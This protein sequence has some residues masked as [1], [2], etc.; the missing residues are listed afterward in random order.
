MRTAHIQAYVIASVLLLLGTDLPAQPASDV[1]QIGDQFYLRTEQVA[2]TLSPSYWYYRQ[3]MDVDEGVC[4][5]FLQDYEDPMYSVGVYLRHFDSASQPLH[6]SLLAD[7][8]HG[9][10]ASQCATARAGD[11]TWTAWSEGGDYLWARIFDVYGVPY[12]DTF[13][14]SELVGMEYD[15]SVCVRSDG[16]RTAIV[17]AD[18]NPN[19]PGYWHDVFFVAYTVDGSPLGSVIPIATITTESE[20]QPQVALL[21]DGAYLVGYREWGGG[22]TRGDLVLRRVNAD[23]TL[24]DP[25]TVAGDEIPFLH[26]N[27]LDDGTVLAAYSMYDNNPQSYAQR[28]DGYGQPIGDPVPLESYFRHAASTSDGRLAL[29][30]APTGSPAWIRIYDSDWL[31]LSGEVEFAR[32]G[33]QWS[34]FYE[35]NTPL[36]Y[37]EDGTIWIAWVGENAAGENAFITSLKPLEVGDANCDGVVDNFDIDPFVLAASNPSQYAIDYPE[38]EALLADMNEDGSVNNFDIDPFV[39]ALVGG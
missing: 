10:Y 23:Y 17:F 24:E 22:I 2:H 33:T 3:A 30:L 36:A 27:A 32:P 1:L 12:G 20:Q 4:S 13:L 39:G 14:V 21:A 25:V 16:T 31:P 35:M 7:P 15:M 37:G 38:C 9:V 26:V 5:L 29:A 6:D 8:A 11:R 19:H 18:D 34:A 28:V